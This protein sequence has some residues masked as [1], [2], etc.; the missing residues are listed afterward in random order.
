MT[1]AG[2]AAVAH[3]RTGGDLLTSGRLGPESALDSRLLLPV[4]T[5]LDGTRDNNARNAVGA[6][7]AAGT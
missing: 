7:L 6:Y 5:L 1:A 3:V 2:G 4:N